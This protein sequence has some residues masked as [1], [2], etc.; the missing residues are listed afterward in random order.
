M[1]L[2]TLT[3]HQPQVKC[4]GCKPGKPLNNSSEIHLGFGFLLQASR[5]TDR[6]VCATCQ[7]RS[8]GRDCTWEAIPVPQ[9]VTVISDSVDIPVGGAP[10]QTNSN[11]AP[12]SYHKQPP[13]STHRPQ[14]DLANAGLSTLDAPRRDT[15]GVVD[16]TTPSASHPVHAIIGATVDE[17][18]CEGF[19]GTVSSFLNRTV[20]LETSVSRLPLS[21]KTDC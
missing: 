5:L 19:F 14:I 2:A 3:E 6:T 9:Y 10:R 7:K 8:S 4:D 12:T 21:I 18:N 13:S 11:I 16:D 20:L 1:P 17:E 15:L